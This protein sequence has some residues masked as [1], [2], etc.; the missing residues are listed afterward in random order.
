MAL[1]DWTQYAASFTSFEETSGAL[2]SVSNGGTSITA[3]VL[4]IR[5][6]V[7]NELL[8]DS[9]GQAVRPS[10]AYLIRKTLLAT[11][12]KPGDHWTEGGET[13][14]VQTV[15]DDQAFWQIACYHP[16]IDAALFDTCD[17][18]KAAE[19][20]T[21]KGTRKIVQ[22]VEASATCRLQPI[23][24]VPAEDSR[25]YGTLDTWEIYFDQNRI[26]QPDVHSIRF[27][28][29]AFRNAVVIGDVVE[30]RN[31]QKIGDLQT[32]VAEVRP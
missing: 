5:G 22:T 29:T 31:A 1:L 10:V 4:A 25:R 15:R 16:K 23:T 11:R 21:T 27:T 19:T 26:V 6:A 9:E 18:L 3:G 30:V 2:A 12:P 8:S 24:S 13:Y 32:V 28:D 20:L 17:I 7:T 14:T